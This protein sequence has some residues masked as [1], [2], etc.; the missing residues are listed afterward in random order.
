[1]TQALSTLI[2]SCSGP[3]AD[4]PPAGAAAHWPA[5]RPGAQWTDAGDR[6]QETA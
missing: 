4:V 1:M 3:S 6:A 2:P 5:G